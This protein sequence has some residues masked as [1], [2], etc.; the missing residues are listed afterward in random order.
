[1]GLGL[2]SLWLLPIAVSLV[3]AVP[4]S[5]LSGLRLTQFRATARALGTPEV[6]AAPPIIRAA[7]AHRA[8]LRQ[9]LAELPEAAE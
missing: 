2:I 6:Y 1:M 4:L 5:A 8:E 7:Q 3:L 9:T